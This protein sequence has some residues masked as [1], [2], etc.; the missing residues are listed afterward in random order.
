[1]HG[2][3]HVYHAERGG[4]NPVNRRSEFAGEPLEVQRRKYQK[5]F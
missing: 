4:M 1:M 2:Y 3:N 5:G